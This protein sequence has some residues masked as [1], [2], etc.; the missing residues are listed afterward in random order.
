MAVFPTACNMSE[1][2]V[3]DQEQVQLRY[4]LRLKTDPN[5]MAVGTDVFSPALRSLPAIQAR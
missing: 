4:L 2:I 3:Y 5:T 1:F